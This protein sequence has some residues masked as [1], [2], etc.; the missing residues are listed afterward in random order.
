M[1][2]NELTTIQRPSHRLT[3]QLSQ[4]IHI[5][6]LTLIL[7]EESSYISID[8]VIT[9]IRRKEEERIENATASMVSF[10]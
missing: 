2:G 1:Y 3:L 4:S 8:S 5:Q 10:L 7:E 6:C 9:V